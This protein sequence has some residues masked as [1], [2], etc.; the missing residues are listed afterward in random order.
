LGGQRL[1]A[2]AGGHI[3]ALADQGA[4]AAGLAPVVEAKTVAI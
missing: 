4:S 2:Q 3:A 1:Q